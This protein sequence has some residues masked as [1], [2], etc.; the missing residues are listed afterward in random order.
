VLTKVNKTE[1]KKIQFTP[2]TQREVKCQ[3]KQ[4][5]PPPPHLLGPHLADLSFPL[6]LPEE[7]QNLVRILSAYIS[8]ACVF[9]R[10]SLECSEESNEESYDTKDRHRHGSWSRAWSRVVCK[11][12]G[13][14][15]VRS[16]G[17][18]PTVCPPTMVQPQITRGKQSPG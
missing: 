6:S 14:H 10:C 1:V 16:I 11:R 4:L 2:E 12:A 7:Y 18:G 9:S 3:T 17:L 15:G 5:T 8:R 13:V